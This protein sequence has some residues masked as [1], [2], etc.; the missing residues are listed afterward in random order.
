MDNFI[1]KGD[2]ILI[3]GPSGGLSSGDPHVVGQIP[4]VACVDI[5][6]SATGEART[7]GV[8]DLP[9]HGYNAS[10]DAAIAVGDEIY[11]DTDELNVDATNGVSFGYALEVVVSGETTTI[12]VFVK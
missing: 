9:V 10:A 4:C 1:K 11:Y 5:A 8:F 7:K 3:T 6:E 2:R 12:K